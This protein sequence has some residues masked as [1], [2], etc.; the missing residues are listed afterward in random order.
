MINQHPVDKII[1]TAMR[2]GA[3]FAEV[4]IEQ[5]RSTTITLDNRKIENASSFFD[6]GIGIRVI[7]E[8]ELHTEPP[9]TF[10][11]KHCWKWQSPS[12]KP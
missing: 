10:Q 11:K 4:F 6:H 9:T 12:E 5:K 7:S 3:D 1:Q 8:E 2:Y